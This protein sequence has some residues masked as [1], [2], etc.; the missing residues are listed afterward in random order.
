MI[1]GIRVGSLVSAY[2]E[3][4][5]LEEVIV[6]R[7]ANAQIARQD[8]SLFAIEYR[9]FGCVENMPSGRYPDHAIAE[10]EE[11]L[12]A[13]VEVFEKA[14]VTVRR[15]DVFDH[16]REFATPHWKTDGQYNYCP[17][18]LFVIA[19]E[20]IIEAP[21]TLR[22]RQA[23][24]LSF[25]AIMRDYLESGARWI[26]APKPILADE[27]YIIGDGSD[28]A[29]AERDPIFDAANVLRIGRDLLYLVSDSGN[30][31]GAKWLQTVLGNQ[32]RVH[33]LQGVYTGSHIDTTITLV[34]PGLVVV[35]AE[36]I[37]PSNLPSIFSKWDVIYLDE[38]H[39]IGYV[40]TPYASEWIGMNFMMLN[41]Q[42]AIVDRR[43]RVLI[44]ELEA[45]RVDVIPLCL[46]HARTMGG[47]FHCVT[48]DVRR[49]GG[50]EDYCS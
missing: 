48:L 13:L 26:S 7:A 46:T 35:N 19:G 29:I 24:T 31:L 37:N 39:D 43:Q 27:D 1:L 22:A 28:I 23:E 14:G 32:Y 11:Q 3:W 50:L 38:V 33:A 5:P 41:P 25:R 6:G 17:R 40:G 47:G 12:E 45:R 10:T 4:D 44:R 9:S 15:P 20:T 18:D 2:N 49:R 8:R 34:R 30:L 21:M 36:R 42:T 16:S